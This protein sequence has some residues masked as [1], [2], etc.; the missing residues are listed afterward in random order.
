MDQYLDFWNMMAYDFC[1]LFYLS[2][3]IIPRL[4]SQPSWLMGLSRTSPSERLWWPNQRV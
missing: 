3:Y 2:P 1:A 4:T